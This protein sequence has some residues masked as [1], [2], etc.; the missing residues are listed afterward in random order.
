MTSFFIYLAGGRLTS[1]FFR[2]IWKVK[3]RAASQYTHCSLQEQIGF[4]QITKACILYWM[5]LP[6]I[7]KYSA[8]GTEIWKLVKN[9]P[10]SYD[11]SHQTAIINKTQTLIVFSGPCREGKGFTDRPSRVTLDSLFLHWPLTSSFMFSL[12]GLVL[13]D[14]CQDS[15][16]GRPPHVFLI[17]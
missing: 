17:F 7:P 11:L 14:V 8:K 4:V 6:H 13:L 3:Q 1:A 10:R 2:T 9:K 12:R 15:Q 16:Y 5:K